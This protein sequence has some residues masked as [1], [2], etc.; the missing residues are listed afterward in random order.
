MLEG[1][2]MLTIHEHKCPDCGEI[3]HKCDCAWPEE[4]ERYL[5]AQCFDRLIAVLQA[6]TGW[7]GKK[8]L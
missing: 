2:Y 3:D 1:G 7:E 8:G 6:R 5:C 4:T